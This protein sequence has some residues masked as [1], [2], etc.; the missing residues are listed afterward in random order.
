MKF[1]P[2]RFFPKVPAQSRSFNKEEQGIWCC[3]KWGSGAPA[4]RE[5]E[6]P[7]WRKQTLRKGSCKGDENERVLFPCLAESQS[8]PS[9]ADV[10]ILEG[11]ARISEQSQSCITD[12][13]SQREKIGEHSPR[14]TI[15]NIRDN[16]TSDETTLI[17][18]SSQPC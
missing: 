5:P 18:A 9:W 10:L 7:W 1:L 17:S 6:R 3:R 2:H 8:E 15:K 14:Q 11:H 16:M 12:L 13:R 4:L